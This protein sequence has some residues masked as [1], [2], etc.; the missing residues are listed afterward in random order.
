M[1]EAEGHPV[2]I[3]LSS[4]TPKTPAAALIDSAF[5]PAVNGSRIAF[6]VRDDGCW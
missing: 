5:L 6:G 2:S 3:L 1:P 4:Y